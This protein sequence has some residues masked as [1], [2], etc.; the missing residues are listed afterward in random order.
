MR[1]AV[2]V[3][4]LLPLLLWA[5]PLQAAVGRFVPVDEAAR[6]S[7]VVIEGI[8]TASEASADERWH[9]FVTRVTVTVEHAWRGEASSVTVLL[10][11]GEVGDLVQLVPGEAVLQVGERVLLFLEPIP[12]RPELRP[13]GMKQGV[14]RPAAEGWRRDFDG[15]SLLDPGAATARPST[16]ETLPLADLPAV[17]RANPFDPSLHLPPATPAKVAP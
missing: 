9:R 16:P 11:G 17:L 4:A 8:V 3:V 1:A 5:A 14:F 7:V 13:V 6:R 15:L 2:A 10:L 12:G